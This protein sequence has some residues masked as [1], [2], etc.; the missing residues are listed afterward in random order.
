MNKEQESVVLD[1]KLATDLFEYLLNM[2]C[3]EVIHYVTALQCVPSVDN[4]FV[5][6]KD[7]I[8]SITKYLLQKPAGHVIRFLDAIRDAKPHIEDIKSDEDKELLTEVSD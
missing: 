8:E 4:A 7:L 2:P 6:R 1:S 5:V 3:R